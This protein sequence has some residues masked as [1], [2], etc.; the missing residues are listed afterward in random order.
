[1]VK[2]KVKAKFSLEQ[3]TKAHSGNRDIAL[4]FFNLGARWGW[5]VSDTLRPLYPEQD[6]IPIV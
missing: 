6:P 4:P 3:A 2:V 1:M 5:V